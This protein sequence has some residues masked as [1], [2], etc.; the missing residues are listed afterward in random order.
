[1]EQSVIFKEPELFPFVREQMAI[2]LINA[3]HGAEIGLRGLR[4]RHLLRRLWDGVTGKGQELHA[5]IGTD[6]VTVQQASIELLREIMGEVERTQ[7]CQ[8]KVLENLLELNHELDQGIAG[9]EKNSESI[10][11]LYTMYQD[12]EKA[13]QKKLNNE[14]EVRRLTT[15]FTAHS[16]YK[17]VGS[18]LSSSLFIADVVHLYFNEAPDI[19]RKEFTTAL[20]IV[21]KSL[22]KQPERMEF[23]IL[24]CIH[25]LQDDRLEAMAYLTSGHDSPLLRTLFYLLERRMSQLPVN[26]AT[27]AEQ[28]QLVRNL[29]DPYRQ[30]Q[31]ELSLPDMFVAQ[32]TQELLSSIDGEA[33][34]WK[35]IVLD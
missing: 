3:L 8:R 19:L 12:L 29:H 24:S 4:S 30:L 10:Q 28:V 7:Y 35:R 17:G 27:V 34:L 33:D 6:I 23:L 5:Q 18:L 15:L 22:K 13:V 11:Q 2:D 26:E 1:M 21:K 14:A 20:A 16:L 9:V 32:L 25:E 31:W